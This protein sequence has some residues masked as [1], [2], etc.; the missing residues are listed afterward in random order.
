MKSFV[1]IIAI[2][3]SSVNLLLTRFVLFGL[4]QPTPVP[5][6]MVKVFSSAISPLLLLLGLLFATLGLILNSILLIVT[7]SIAALLYLLHIIRTTRPADP[8]TALE[9]VFGSDW[10]NNLPPERIASFLPG[11]YVLRLPSHPEPILDRNI[12]FYTIPDTD[13]HLL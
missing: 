9:R 10:K 4:R 3:L 13:R 2:F 1:E 12:T 8:S 11:R 6:W 5:V 7:G